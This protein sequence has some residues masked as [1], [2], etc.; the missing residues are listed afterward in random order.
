MGFLALDRMKRA[1]LTVETSPLDRIVLLDM[2]VAVNDD[3]TIYSWGHERLAL[4]LGKPPRSKAARSAVD[5]VIARLTAN[6]RIRLTAKPHPGRS[7]EYDLL[8][9]RNDA[10]RSD[11][12][13]SEEAAVEKTASAQNNAPRSSDECAPVWDEMHPGLTGAPLPTTTPSLPT[14]AHRERR[15]PSNNATRTPGQIAHLRD[16]AMALGIEHDEIAASTEA[17]ARALA[18]DLRGEV[19]RRIS[20][21]EGF[22]C[23]LEDLSPEG[24]RYYA[25]RG[26]EHLFQPLNHDDPFANQEGDAA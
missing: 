25:D 7:A 10:P 9:I 21:M 19:Y 12:G 15:A 14:N 3:S 8:L 23:A 2:A 17:D 24:Q 5:R 22:D 4:A 18:S 11:R 13:A 6:G 1:L 16:L 20:T 26:H